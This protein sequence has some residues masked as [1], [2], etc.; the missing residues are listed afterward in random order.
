M[1]EYVRDNNGKFAETSGG[2]SKM[3]DDAIRRATGRP[4][5]QTQRGMPDN[6]SG[7]S[8]SLKGG[9]SVGVNRRLDGSITLDNNGRE[10]AFTKDGI[11]RLLSKLTLADDWDRGD[12]ERVD[13]NTVT[14]IG[15]DRYEATLADGTRLQLTHRD[16]VKLEQSIGRSEGSSRIDTG[17]GDVDI[18][19]GD[20]TVGIRHLGDDGRPVEVAFDKRSYGRISDAIGGIIDDIDLAEP[21]EEPK[22]QRDV[23]TNAGKVRIEINERG[24]MSITP[25]GSTAW[26]IVVDNGQSDAWYR[27][28]SNAGE[29]MEWL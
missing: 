15:P 29:A 28:W 18:V 21:G 23:N 26:G 9:G 13:G 7:T 22:R 4:T 6:L 19:V 16:I 27:A 2:V 5:T 3:A 25:V 8:V 17:Y 20:K 12:S 10:A 14:K 1:R 11:R 24:T